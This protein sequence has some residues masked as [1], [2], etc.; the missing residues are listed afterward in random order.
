MSVELLIS[1]IS[2][3]I[4]SVELVHKLLGEKIL[5][6]LEEKKQEIMNR[7]IPKSDVE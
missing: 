6:K 4:D 2:E 1:Q 7:L 5:D 3:D